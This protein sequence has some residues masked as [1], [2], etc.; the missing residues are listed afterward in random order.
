MSDPAD[1]PN[2]PSLRELVQVLAARIEEFE[3]LP[4]PEVRERIF[5]TLQLLDF[6]HR[7]GLKQVAA[8]LEAD[9]KLAEY[10]G[11]DDIALLFTLYDLNPNDPT[12]AVEQALEVVRP[13]MRSH[14]GEVEVLDV[15]DGLVHVRL[16]GACSSC[17]ASSATLK[18]GI[19]AALRDGLPG[20]QGLVV[21]ESE[22][23]PLDPALIELPM[24]G[25]HEPV[26]VQAPVFKEVATLDMLAVPSASVGQVGTNR[27]LLVRLEDGVTAFEATCACGQSLEGSKLSSTVLVCGW[28][29]AAFD[30][31][32]GRRADGQ[33]GAGLRVYPVS[34]QGD[35][36]LLAA[37]LAPQALFVGQS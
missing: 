31:R 26:T 1:N 23:E 6:V 19:E 9:G 5:A 17:A 15:V 11:N 25:G 27:V 24:L 12:S 18:H 14:G 20:F 16:Q 33:L 13:Y 22:P 30:A 32:S 29:N 10:L 7:V 35:R 2:P 34:V 28:C 36:V 3:S 21:H 4:F 8:R 37:D